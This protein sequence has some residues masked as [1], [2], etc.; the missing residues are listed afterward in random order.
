MESLDDALAGA[1]DIIA[2]TINEDSGAR[3]AMRA[4][5]KGKA[6]LRSRAIAAEEQKG[7]KF[8]DYI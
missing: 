3:A 2:E 8:K 1:R 7:E 6:V 5:Y 4:I